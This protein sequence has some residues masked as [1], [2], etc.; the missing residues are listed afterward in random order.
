LFEWLIIVFLPSTKERTLFISIPNVQ[1]ILY[2]LENH[3]H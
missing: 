2:V 1:K 3:D